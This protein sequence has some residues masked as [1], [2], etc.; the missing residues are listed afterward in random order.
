M[1]PLES[2][3]KGG[4]KTLVTSSDFL[5]IVSPT[6]L[7]DTFEKDEEDLDAEHISLVFLL[8]ERWEV[9]MIWLFSSS[10]EVMELKRHGMEQ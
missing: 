6:S 8:L 10:F 5:G 1:F 7:L 9:L 4:I 2:F 3:G